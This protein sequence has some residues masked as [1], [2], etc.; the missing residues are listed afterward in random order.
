MVDAPVS[1]TGDRKVVQV[2]V[3]SWA[4]NTLILLAMKK[5]TL[6]I[7]LFFCVSG[8]LTAQIQKEYI[9]KNL[10]KVN[11]TSLI[12][13]N[14]MFQYERVLGKR[15]SIA[16]SYRTM[17][18]STVPFKDFII[19]Q[20]DDNNDESA[21]DIINSVKIGNSALTPEIRFYLGNKGYG[22]GFYIAPFYRSASFKGEGSNIEFTVSEQQTTYVTSFTGDLSMSTFGLMFGAQ[23]SLGR[24]ICLDWWILGPHFG[25]GS[26]EFSLTS[27]QE[28]STEI[29]NDLRTKLEDIDIPSY[30]KTVTVNNH[31]ATMT[32]DGKMGGIRAGILLGIKF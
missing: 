16:F 22:R 32:L 25:N 9:P 3:L 17:P 7:A 4:P 31:G 8:G 1:G 12:L 11:L 23:W 13:N 20:I 24:N 27:D 29:Q 28:L 5:L 19:K 21:S 6:I 2:R 30:D 18:Y 14:Y 10:F 15:V 26:G